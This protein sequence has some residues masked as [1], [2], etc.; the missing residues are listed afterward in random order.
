MKIACKAPRSFGTL[1]VCM[2]NREIK[3]QIEQIEDGDKTFLA[4]LNRMFSPLQHAGITLPFLKMIYE[5]Y[6]WNL[7][8]YGLPSN[9][10][11][12][13][14]KGVV[15]GGTVHRSVNGGNWHVDKFIDMHAQFIWASIH[16]TEFLLPKKS[17]SASKSEDV[18]HIAKELEL[19]KG[20]KIYQPAN[21]TIV[22][23]KHHLHRSPIIDKDC[24]REFFRMTFIN[25]RLSDWKDFIQ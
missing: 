25:R 15:K 23:A 7:I 2:S 12:T 21:G 5:L 9:V 13:F 6:E 11:L 22:L 24:T 19:N 18:Q 20:A 10:I 16:C 8:K 4:Y 3:W 1:N 17:T 14:D